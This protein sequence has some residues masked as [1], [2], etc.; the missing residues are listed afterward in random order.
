MNLKLGPVKKAR[1]PN[2][3]IAFK[4][5][6]AGEKAPDYDSIIIGYAPVENPQFAYSLFA[7]HAGRA[8]LE[9]ARIIKELLSESIPPK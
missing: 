4:T 7:L 2:Y 5:G 3:R 6:T 1:L 8:S 9:G